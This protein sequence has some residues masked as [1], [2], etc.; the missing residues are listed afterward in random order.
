[1]A[2]KSSTVRLEP[3]CS[4]YEAHKFST[5]NQKARAPLGDRRRR[6]ENI[7]EN[8]YETGVAWTGLGHIVSW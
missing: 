4:T 3:L 8:I 5:G 7:K 6:E 1:M 2:I